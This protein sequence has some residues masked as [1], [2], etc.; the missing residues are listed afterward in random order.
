[1][2]IKIRA[3]EKSE[4]SLEV[5]SESVSV[6][7]TSFL[8]CMSQILIWTTLLRLSFTYCGFIH[9]KPFVINLKYIWFSNIIILYLS[10]L[11][12]VLEFCIQILT[13]FYEV[14]DLI[15]FDCDNTLHERR[16]TWIQNSNIS[17]T[18]FNNAVLTTE[19]T[20]LETL[21]MLIRKLYP[22]TLFIM[23]GAVR[24]LF[25]RMSL[26]RDWDRRLQA[27]VHSD[28]AVVS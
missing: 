20:A 15:N 27:S 21:Q 7:G 19:V 4:V 18:L 10:I 12:H 3:N 16:R 26:V 11:L 23:N 28:D 25:F 8:N 9:F 13:K 17:F 6:D 24:C 22:Q 14:L 2:Q 5:Q 1:M